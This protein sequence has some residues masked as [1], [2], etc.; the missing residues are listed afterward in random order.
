M[1]CSQFHSLPLCGRLKTRARELSPPPPPRIDEMLGPPVPFYP[2][3]GEGSPTKTDYGKKGTLILSSL[4]EDLGSICPRY[5]LWLN[6]WHYFQW[7]LSRSVSR[8]VSREFSNGNGLSLRRILARDR[9][10]NP[11]PSPKR[12]GNG[13]RP[14]QRRKNRCTDV[15]YTCLGCC[16]LALHEYTLNLWGME[17]HGC[18]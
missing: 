10:P 3:S 5:S 15:G 1:F 6:P 17:G 2:C 14:G 4:L 11:Q 7:P 12:D 9:S 18:T 16:M 13:E 8:S